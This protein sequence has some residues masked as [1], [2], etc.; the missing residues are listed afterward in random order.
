MKTSVLNLNLL[1]VF[2]GNKTALQRC[3]LPMPEGPGVCGPFFVCFTVLARLPLPLG[4]VGVGA[5]LR[6]EFVYPFQPFISTWCSSHSFLRF[7][8]HRD[9]IEHKILG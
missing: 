6:S 7:I 9:N 4:P 5:G 3:V 8:Y 1:L 2:K